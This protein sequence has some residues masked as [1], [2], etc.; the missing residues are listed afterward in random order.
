MSEAFARMHLRDT[1]RHDDIDHAIAVT[2]GSFIST[3][4]QSVQKTLQSVFEKYLTVEK[5]DF[6]LLFYILADIQ[7]E[8]I[9]Y[10]YYQKGNMDAPVEID[11]EELEGRA[12]ESNIHDLQPFL[13]SELFSKGFIFDNKSL[14]IRPRVQ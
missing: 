9:N 7:K 11:I 5:D 4:K 14:K 8:H 3:Q 6:E 10:N 12:R 1:V 2:I 13:N